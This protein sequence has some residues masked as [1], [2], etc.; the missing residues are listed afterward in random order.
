MVSTPCLIAAAQPSRPWAARGHPVAQPVASSVTAASSGSVSWSGIGVLEL[1]ERAPVV[2]ILTKSAPH[3]ICSLTARLMSSGPSAS[4]YMSP[5]APARC[6]G[7]DDL[8]AGQAEP[9]ERAVAHGLP[10][11]LRHQP[12]DPQTR[13]GGHAEAQVVAEVRPAGSAPRPWQ[14]RPRPPWRCA[15]R[16]R[17]RGARRSAW[18]SAPPAHVD[19]AGRRPG[20]APGRP[21]TRRMTLSSTRD[22]GV[23]AQR[24]PGT[25]EAAPR[26][27]RAAPRL[28]PGP[29]STPGTCASRRYHPFPCTSAGVPEQ[30]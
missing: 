15:V 12:R 18:A 8:P 11:L 28:G 30:P 26:S 21:A 17:T 5:V 2:I 13:M 6:R 29:R 24:R 9:A 7:R 25:V 23:L 3:R 22:R 14:R 4:R 19:R 1:V 27:A 20:T 10:G 16:G